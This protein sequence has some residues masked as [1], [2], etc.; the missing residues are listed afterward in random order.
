MNSLKRKADDAFADA[1]VQQPF[2]LRKRQR[3]DTISIANIV[4]CQSAPS[5]VAF[6]NQKPASTIRTSPDARLVRAV[7]QVLTT[8]YRSQKKVAHDMGISATKLSNYL[9]GAERVK[10]WDA[11]EKKLVAWLNKFHSKRDLE[12][13]FDAG[14][15][16]Y[17]LP[18]ACPTEVKIQNLGQQSIIPDV[19]EST[20]IFVES[21]P[22]A[23][24]AQSEN[25]FSEPSS[26]SSPLHDT[27][28]YFTPQHDTSSYEVSSPEN[29]FFSS[30]EAENDW[31]EAA[32]WNDFP[33]FEHAF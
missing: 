31:I 7:K 17:E 26:V 27:E 28:S 8:G 21:E 11:T 1:P 32:S 5:D 13:L 19:P 23:Y 29:Y 22:E 18:T 33:N 24:Y 10:G 12:G 20:Q 16:I 9:N 25:A 30:P 6:H 4:A 3:G 15:A 14:A 2:P